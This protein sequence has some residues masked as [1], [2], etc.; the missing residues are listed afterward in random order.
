MVWDKLESG[1]NAV[2]GGATLGL[3]G[4]NPFS[5]LGGMFGEA[6]AERQERLLNNE[7]RGVNPADFQV[8]G[9]EQLGNQR[10][11][12]AN[13]FLAQGAPQAGMS[14]FRGDQAQLIRML[15]S[16]AAGQGPGQEIARLQAANQAQDGIKN[17]LSQAA[18]QRGGASPLAARMAAQN[19]AG[20]SGA[21][22]NAATMGGLNAQMG[23]IGALGQNIGM[24]RGADEAM[25]QF[26]VQATLQNRQQQQ[27]AALEALRQQLMGKD[28]QQ[29]GMIAGQNART[30]RFASIADAGKE[31]MPTQEAVGAGFLSGILEAAM[32]SKK[33]GK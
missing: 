33:G 9:L 15:Q 17:Q 1:G 10:L 27:Q 32:K 6:P 2:L 3:A 8:P 4:T 29:Q 28:L 23:A 31:N 11:G 22:A 12:L 24:A 19:S 26:N 20:I 16:Q 5:T 18:S 21:A 30:A 13:Q 7:F 14:G 25:N